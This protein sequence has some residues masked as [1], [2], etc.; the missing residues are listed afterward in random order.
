MKRHRVRLADIAQAAGVTVQ[1]VSHVLLGRARVKRISVRLEK[2]IQ[3]L[4]K[5]LGYRPNLLARSLSTQRSMT[6]GVL[7]S[8]LGESFY[9]AVMARLHEQVSKHGYMLFFSNHYMKSDLFREEVSVLQQRSVDAL[10][11]GPVPEIERNIHEIRNIA[12]HCS[13]VA[14]DWSHPALDSALN[15]P[16]T[17]GRAAADYLLQK[18]VRRVLALSLDESAGQLHGL[19]FVIEGRLKWFQKRFESHP[20]RSTVVWHATSSDDLVERLRRGLALGQL[21][22]FDG[23]FFPHTIAAEIF[24]TELLGAAHELLRRMALVAIGGDPSRFY[25]RRHM[26]IF[27]QNPMVLGDHLAERLL[28]QIGNRN[29][30]PQITDLPSELIERS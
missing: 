17:L 16:Q 27:Y 3:V 24:L 29:F 12:R 15:R 4:A 9:P 22:E 1:T 2:K 11:L 18:D 20:G 19:H 5:R 13:V 30:T 28:A 7:V 8:N 10:V 14:F 26:A 25:L 21:S 6:I 23:I